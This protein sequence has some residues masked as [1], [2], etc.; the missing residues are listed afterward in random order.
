MASF[1]FG[2]G[3]YF[4]SSHSQICPVL[5]KERSQ[6]CPQFP[7]Q[8]AHPVFFPVNALYQ[9]RIANSTATTRTPARRTPSIICSA[10]YECIQG[11]CLWLLN[12]L[13]RRKILA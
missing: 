3:L 5:W 11:Y 2:Y 12:N 6:L 8:F 7:K 9:G 4:L 1:H 10:P 13:V